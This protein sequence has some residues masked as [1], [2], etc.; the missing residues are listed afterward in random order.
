L[1]VLRIWF[2][3]LTFPS[4]FH[5]DDKDLDSMLKNRSRWGDPMAHLVKNKGP[6][7]DQ[8][9]QLDTEE[10]K[11]QGFIVPQEVPSHSWLKRGLAPPYNRFGIRPGR[12]WDGVD[13]STGFEKEIVKSK[14]AKQARANEAY[15]WS[16]SDM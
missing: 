3:F 2:K 15:L 6:S 14:N 9:G 10:M 13:R 11:A 5:R 12:H 1:D 4:S 7:E 16:V 8:L